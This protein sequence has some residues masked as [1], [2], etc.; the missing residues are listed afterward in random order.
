MVWLV[1]RG[2]AEGC[3]LAWQV[4]PE[5]YAAF[6]RGE[7][8]RRELVERIRCALRR[9]QD[10][11]LARGRIDTS[12]IDRLARVLANGSFGRC[13]HA[14]VTTNWDTLLELALSPHG[15][16]VWHLNGSIDGG[17]E[18]LTE[19][20][21]RR[22]RDAAM[23]RNPGFRLLLEAETCVLAGL[24]L[25]SRPDRELVERMGAE[26]HWLPAG[27]TWLL[28]NHDRAELARVAAMLRE[29]LPRSSVV[30]VGLPFEQWVAAGLPE[31]AAERPEEVGHGG[32]V[33]AQRVDAR[34]ARRE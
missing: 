4:P 21:E 24:S 34:D 25:K 12:S 19:L 33:R 11:A 7:L 30:P 15:H 8:A 3:G 26:Q 5:W 6:R 2:I 32:A 29:R 13:E 1:G 20:D 9:A 22:G 31:L 10:D 27:D 16:R 28:V 17:G 23:T 14:F 18:L